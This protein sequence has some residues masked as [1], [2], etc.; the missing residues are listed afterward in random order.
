MAE[1]ECRGARSSGK[2]A[3]VMKDGVIFRNTLN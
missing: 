1:P 3:L 2:E